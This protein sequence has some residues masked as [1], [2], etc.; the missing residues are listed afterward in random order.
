MPNGGIKQI[1]THHVNERDSYVVV[2]QLSPEFTAQLVDEWKKLKEDQAAFQV[3]QSMS[4]A[5]LLAGN[6]A[7]E[8]EKKDA[9]ITKL[10]TEKA[11]IEDKARASAMGTASA[12]VKRP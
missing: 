2:A 4:E 8:N 3:P 10:H 12:A 9:Q 5:L 6:L 7:L 1:T 11:W